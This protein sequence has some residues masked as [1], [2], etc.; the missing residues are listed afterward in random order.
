MRRP[1]DSILEPDQLK[2]VQR[3]A[4]HLLRE[5]SA[6]G[7]FP[8]PVGDLMAVAKLTVV[9][10]AVLNESFLRHLMK[11]ARAG[12]ETLKSALGK[13]LGLFDAGERVVVLD[14]EIPA[15]R[16]PFIKLHETGHGTLPHQCRAYKFMHDCERTLDPEIRD[17]F[18]REANVFASEVLFQGDVFSA[19]A[20]EQTFGIKAPMYLA[21]KFGASN[22]SSFRRYVITSAHA[23]CVV[24]L[25]PLTLDIAGDFRANVRRV[26]ASES[27]HKLYDCGSLCSS[28][29]RSDPLGPVI[30]VAPKRMTSQREIVLIDRNHDERACI[31]EAFDTKHQILVLVRDVG[32]RTKS[33]IVIPRSAVRVLSAFPATCAHSHG[34]KT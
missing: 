28:V 20:H 22:Y 1:D 9:D 26:I 25:D 10:D 5:A 3:Y 16:V 15:P 13:V 4:D 6:L 33:G 8:T 11:K 12:V 30:P 2:T 18:E 7:R 19:E 34:R 23:C 32:P 29:T 27:F 31:G 24:V 17:L 21:K 14:S